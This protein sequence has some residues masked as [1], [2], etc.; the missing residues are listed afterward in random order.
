[1]TKQELAA[2]LDGREYPFELTP[3]EKK[4]AKA[5]SLVVICGASDDLAEF[6]GAIDDELGAPD[7]FLIFEGK[8]LPEVTDEDEEVL[9][10]HGV[11]D[12]ADERRSEAVKIKVE[13][14]GACQWIVGT[15]AP[16]AKFNIME[17]FGF[18]GGKK[19]FCKAI[20]IDLK[21]LP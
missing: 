9:R 13:W 18:D 10:K 15:K 14:G 21:E 17:D 1:M 8:L 5:D 20:V 6:A 19:V 2:Q 12:M 16:H 3:E 4:Q 11:F 7:E